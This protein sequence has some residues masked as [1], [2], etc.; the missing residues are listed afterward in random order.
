[1]RSCVRKDFRRGGGGLKLVGQAAWRPTG[2]VPWC[3]R[4][5]CPR[6]VLLSSR[7][8]AMAG[9]RVQPRTPRSSSSAARTGW[10]VWERTESGSGRSW[11]SSLTSC[12]QKHT[13]SATTPPTYSRRYGTTP[14]A[15]GS[16][17]KTKTTLE[18]E[19]VVVVVLRTRG[20]GGGFW[21]QAA[22]HEVS[23]YGLNILNV[24][25]CTILH[26]DLNLCWVFITVRFYSKPRILTLTSSRPWLGISQII[27]LLFMLCHAIVFCKKK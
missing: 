20:W 5:L 23:L 25:D 3:R 13:T 1:M 24:Y 12:C 17:I 10:G 6:T 9:V 15:F 27:R 26:R 7:P 11:T 4:W 8:L 14:R 2:T 21:Y 18:I 19:V 22:S 16:L